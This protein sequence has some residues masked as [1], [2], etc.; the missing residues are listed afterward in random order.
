MAQ[1][2]ILIATGHTEDFDLESANHCPSEED[3]K[4]AQELGQLQLFI[5]VFPQE[6]IG[7][8]AFFGPT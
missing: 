5:A 6:S 1:G 2:G 8:L 3:A 4:L 7:Q